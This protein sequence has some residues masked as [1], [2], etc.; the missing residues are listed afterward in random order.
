MYPNSL[1][2]QTD[3]SDSAAFTARQGSDRRGAPRV[4]RD[5]SGGFPAGLRHEHQPR[6]HR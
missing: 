2:L 1:L 5:D 3:G 6:P 4:H